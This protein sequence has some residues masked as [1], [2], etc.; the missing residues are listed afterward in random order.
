[1]NDAQASVRLDKWLWAARFY[2][3]R[4]QAVEAI[5]GG[6]VHLNGVRVKP[7][8]SVQCGDELVVRKS[9]MEFVVTV[10]ALSE[11]RG[12]APVAQQ[13]YQESE[14]SRARRE[15]LAEERRLAAAAGVLPARRPDKRGRRQIIRFTSR[16]T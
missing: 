13:L 6:H 8:R 9:G 7:A 2:K 12:P 11:Q 1:M 10:R 5:N 15:S 4:A 16:G 3:T 14:D